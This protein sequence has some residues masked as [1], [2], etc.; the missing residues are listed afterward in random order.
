MECIKLG[1]RRRVRGED[2]I[3]EDT[4][5]MSV[6]R[7]T[8]QPR[9]EI[10]VPQHVQVGVRSQE[11]TVMAPQS[12]LEPSV[13]LFMEAFIEPGLSWFKAGDLPQRHFRGD[14]LE[15]KQALTF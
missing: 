9:T 15:C 13:E 2:R 3:P 6:T 5:V 4:I 12:I 1:S 14:S 8:V 10:L 7:K 11:H